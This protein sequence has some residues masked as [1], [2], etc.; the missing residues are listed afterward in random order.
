VVDVFG[1]RKPSFEALREECSPVHS[2]SIDR[3]GNSFRVLVRSRGD[4]PAYV[5]RGYRVRAV[6]YGTGEIPLEQQTAELPEIAP[7]HEA[8][9][10]LAFAGALPA[11]HIRFDVLRPSGHSALSR[12]FAAQ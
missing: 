9:V 11:P 1:R 3:H 2:L 4:L 6:S 5:L 7:G 12:E 10:E 8:L